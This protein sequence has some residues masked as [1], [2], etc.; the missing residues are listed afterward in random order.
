MGKLAGLGTYSVGYDGNFESYLRY[1]LEDDPSTTHRFE[2][3]VLDGRATYFR[4]DVIN[5]SE[6]ITGQ[7]NLTL[8]SGWTSNSEGIATGTVTKID[9]WYGSYSDYSGTILDVAYDGATLSSLIADAFELTQETF[10][11]LVYSLGAGIDL[12]EGSEGDDFVIQTDVT[13]PGIIDLSYGNDTVLV[14]LQATPSIQYIG[15]HGYDVFQLY[16]FDEGP[17]TPVLDL[18]A[19]TYTDRW[20]VTH[21]VASDFEEYRGSE[22]D[23]IFHLD[24]FETLFHG[25]GGN[26]VFHDSSWNETIVAGDGNDTIYSSIGADTIDSGGGND[27]IISKGSG[28]LVDAGAGAD[29]VSVGLAQISSSSYDGGDEDYS[30]D[31]ISFADV[32]GGASTISFLSRTFTDP[33][34]TVHQMTNFWGLV[35]SAHDDVVYLASDTVID[36]SHG[37]NYTIHDSASSERISGGA[38]NDSLISSLGADTLEGG[39]GNDFLRVVGRLSEMHGGAGNDFLLVGD[40]PTELM[41]VYD[42]WGGSGD[43]TFSMRGIGTIHL[44]DLENGVLVDFD[45]GLITGGG[46]TDRMIS[47]WS[48]IGTDF[49]DTFKGA[50]AEDENGFKPSMHGGLG[51]DVFYGTSGVIRYWG[52]EGDDT[53]YTADGF[54][55]FFGGD[56]DDTFIVENPT[57]RNSLQGGEGSDLYLVDTLAVNVVDNGLI[58][59]DV[60]RLTMQWIHDPLSN[61]FEISHPLKS[62]DIIE[63]SEDPDHLVLDWSIFYDP[64]IRGRGGDDILEIAGKDLRIEGGSGDDA[65]TIVMPAYHTVAGSDTLDGGPGADTMDAIGGADTYIVDNPLD[66]VT[67]T[68]DDAAIDT[69]L[70]SGADSFDFTGVDWTGV[71]RIMAEDPSAILDART[72]T[73]DAELVGAAGQDT[74][75]GGKFGSALSGG[76]GG[77]LLIGDGGLADLAAQFPDIYADLP[78]V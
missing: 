68:G 60:L 3:V 42:A 27:L 70:I 53:F 9:F 59:T 20:G 54:S 45:T 13:N 34:G 49:N 16:A 72:Y 19:G 43:D 1:F 18:G 71:E 76:Q 55:F 64:I 57:T 37:G 44:D 6:Y 26:D 12:I 5:G 32:A 47:P 66:V 8:D 4:Y 25:G 7:I 11:A 77:D 22:A 62:V 31:V 30:V 74:I 24:R 46:E 21:E 36:V 61:A 38:G 50:T 51:D 33:W 78:P 56:G 58:G 23:E 14:G 17:E 39:D 29:T 28:S 69:I 48:V 41:P 65:L 75:L 10:D 67:D 15:G 35:L 63:G 40:D 52:D 2:Y 73:G